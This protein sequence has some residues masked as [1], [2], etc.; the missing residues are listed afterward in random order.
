MCV[1]TYKLRMN[2][3]KL[4][5]SL[6]LLASSLLINLYLLTTSILTARKFITTFQAFKIPTF[7]QLINLTYALTIY[8]HKYYKIY[9]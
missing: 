9:F 7:I 1:R 3:N 4:D 2:E 5:N 8:T 6:A